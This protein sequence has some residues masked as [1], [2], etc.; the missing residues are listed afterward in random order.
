MISGS[1]VTIPWQ[2]LDDLTEYEWYVT[3]SDGTTYGH[4]PGLV[5]HHRGRSFYDLPSFGWI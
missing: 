1:D 2:N 5:I 3:V 4:Q